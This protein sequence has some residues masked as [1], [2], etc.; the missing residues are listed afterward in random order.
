MK[1]KNIGYSEKENLGLEVWLFTLRLEVGF[2]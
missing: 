1:E 2:K